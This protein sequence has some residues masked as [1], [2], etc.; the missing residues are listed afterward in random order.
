[1]QASSSCPTDQQYV[2]SYTYSIDLTSSWTNQSVVLNKIPKDGPPVVN[3]GVLWLDAYQNSF[4][5]YDGSTSEADGIIAQPGA[6]ALWQFFPDGA[7]SGTWNSVSAPSNTNFSQLSRCYAAAFDSGEGLGFALGGVQDGQTI[8]GYTEAYPAGLVI[9]N[10]SSETWLNVS[11]LGYS[12]DGTSERAAAHFVPSFGPN[13]LLFVL[14]G[15]IGYSEI[16]VDTQSVNFFD[17]VSQQWKIQ[18][19]S[20]TP[21]PPSADSCVVGA[22]GDNGTYEVGQHFPVSPISY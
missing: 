3:Q 6:N 9:Y 13:G 10:T 20:G 19:V 11:T 16:Y 18:A 2:D 22:P 8:K 15:Q 14:G 12:S 5:A 17:P 1:M 21:P 7:G 4:Y